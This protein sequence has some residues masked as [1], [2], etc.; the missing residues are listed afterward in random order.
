MAELAAITGRE[1]DADPGIIPNYPPCGWEQRGYV[2]TFSGGR[3]RASPSRGLT[4][5]VLSR[6]APLCGVKRLRARPSESREQRW[7][8][9]CV[10]GPE[11]EP[12]GARLLARAT[13][14][15]GRCVVGRTV[16]RG[17]ELAISDGQLFRSGVGLGGEKCCAGILL[18]G[19]MRGRLDAAS[20]QARE[21]GGN[22]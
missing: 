11:A 15:G 3:P 20:M 18:G 21:F 10:R 7:M 22:R 5:S 8:W 4:S 19:G 16:P 1:R 6:A 12:L 14:P 17:R 2:Y 9:M 13:V